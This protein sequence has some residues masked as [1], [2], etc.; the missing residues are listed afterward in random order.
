M[1]A[2]VLKLLMPFMVLCAMGRSDLIAGITE[3]T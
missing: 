1:G 3:R 2:L